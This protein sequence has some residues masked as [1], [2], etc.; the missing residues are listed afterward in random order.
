MPLIKHRQI[1][2]DTWNH[3]EDDAPIPA[4]GGAIV[5]LERWRSERSTLMGRNAPIGVRLASD[6]TADDIADDLGRFSLVALD[7]PTFKDGRAYSTARL[8]RERHHFNGEL[9][10]VGNILRDQLAFLGRCGFDSFEYEGGTEAQEALN[11][12]DDVEPVYQTAADR[13]RTAASIRS[14][15][16]GAF[17]NGT[18]G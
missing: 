2:V 14:D 11:S 1:V 5:S 13:R 10:A 9:R 3:V 6:Q 16:S 17:L 7:F 12:F 4:D 15:V 18:C 8:L